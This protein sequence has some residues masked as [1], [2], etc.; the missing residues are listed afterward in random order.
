MTAWWQ[1]AVSKSGSLLLLQKRSSLEAEGQGSPCNH[2][3]VCDLVWQHGDSML[4]LVRNTVS[5]PS[6][7]W[8]GWL[9]DIL[10]MH[11]ITSCILLYIPLPPTDSNVPVKPKSFSFLLLFVVLLGVLVF[12][13]IW[14][15]YNLCDKWRVLSQ[16]HE[17][18]VCFYCLC[19]PVVSLITCCHKSCIS[20]FTD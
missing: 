10:Q 11:S 2:H 9:G 19:S 12:G 6:V 14:I 13:R 3:S 4:S 20:A 17:N 15:E 8:R 5:H 7:L 18:C 16:Y 1:H